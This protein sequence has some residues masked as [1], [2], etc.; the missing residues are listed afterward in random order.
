MDFYASLTINR[1]HLESLCELWGTLC[2]DSV[3]PFH[4]VIVSPLFARNGILLRLYQHRKQCS[5]IFDSGGFHIQQGRIGLR[6]A[7]RRLRRVYRENDWAERFALP[8]APIT[9]LDS[10]ETVRRKL[11]STRRQYRT[12]PV[13]FP[14][15]MRP[16]LL[17]VVHGTNPEEL[18]RSMHAARRVGSTSLGFG[19]FSTSGPNA[20]VNSCT[21]EGLRL[22]VQFAALCVK[23]KL[24]AHVFGIGGPPALVLLQYARVQSFDSAGWIRTAAYGNVYLPY[25]GAV[26]ITGAADSRRYVTRRELGQLRK[27]TQHVCPFCVDMAL[28]VRSW[29]HRALHNYYTV[30][31]TAQALNQTSTRQA[32]EKLR[33]FNPRFAVYLELL[34]EEHARL[35]RS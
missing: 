17:P 26:N 10:R 22:L 19:G 5:V 15:A 27:L 12:F 2:G 16:R 33:R 7:S 23:W 24:A 13:A 29:R 4:N 1:C 9:S 14:N 30:E 31:Q 3:F 34:I 25:L 6:L 21:P 20:G 32:L 35:L 8:D 18:R 28:L 11:E